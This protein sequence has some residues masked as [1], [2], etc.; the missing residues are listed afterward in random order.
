MQSTF[1]AV[2]LLS[3]SKL[4][5]MNRLSPS[6]ILFCFFVF[7]LATAS[8]V[9][10]HP[11]EN[12]P[13][14]GSIVKT[15]SGYIAGHPARNRTAVSEY[16][17]IPYAKP[18]VRDLRFA[19]PQSFHSTNPFNASRFSPDCPAVPSKRVKLPGA[20]VN[21][22]GIVAHFTEQDEHEPKSEDCLT[23]NIWTKGV[24]RKP[25]AVLVWFYGGRFSIGNTN[26][27]FY[28]GQY[29]AADENLVVVTFNYRINIFGFS[30]APGEPQNVG[31]LDQRLAVEW[32]QTNI[33]GFGGDAAK[34]TFAGQSAGA[35]SIDYHLHAF[36]AH[37]IARAVIL[38]SGTAASFPPNTPQMTSDAFLAVASLVGCGSSPS[39]T[40]TACMRQI[41]ATAIMN[42][43]T[44]I[45]FGPTRALFQPLWQP[46]VD[47]A[48]IFPDYGARAARRDFAPLPAM[49]GNNGYEPGFYKLAAFA[50]NRTLSDRQWVDFQ[51]EGFTC[52]ASGV[53]AAH[54]E[55]VRPTYRYLFAAVTAELALTAS[56]GA[57]HGSEIPLVFGS[58]AEVVE[59]EI[60]GGTKRLER[61]VMRTWAA[62]VKDPVRGLERLRWRRY[63]PGCKFEDFLGGGG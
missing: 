61:F 4:L 37:P 25:K 38:Q 29:L 57:Y 35:V 40:T 42:A 59:G 52:P 28:D 55:V 43:T 27:T 19:A 48:T 23:L 14:V 3:L 60:S 11:G 7:V 34:I 13:D 36:K 51:Q 46:T 24:G 45:P 63:R 16:L 12:H 1:S 6:T 62:F 53:A 56:S 30:G 44:R 47:N 10:K 26:T 50:T 58:T 15:S 5:K 2:F 31:I 20:T 9:P 33:A 32:V 18:P 21:E 22:P 17:G 49:I 39:R 8:A 41:N 54:A